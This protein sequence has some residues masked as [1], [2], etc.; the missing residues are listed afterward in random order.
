[1]AS[2]QQVMKV[3]AEEYF[4]KEISPE[5]RLAD[6]GD[7]LD[8]HMAR[9]ELEDRFACEISDGEVGT[10]ETVQHVINTMATK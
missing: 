2:A 1:M 9:I 6:L 8:L 10:W 7:S 5:T 4:V 3:I